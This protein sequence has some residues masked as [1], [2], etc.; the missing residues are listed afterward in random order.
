[1]GNRVYVGVCSRGLFNVGWVLFCIILILDVGR[2][3]DCGIFSTGYVFRRGAQVFCALDIRFVACVW[4]FFH[5]ALFDLIT[6]IISLCSVFED[7]IS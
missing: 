5:V 2:C 7:V 6:L 1:L 4:L 3:V